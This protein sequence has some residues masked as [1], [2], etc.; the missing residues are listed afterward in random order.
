MVK[1]SS[2]PPGAKGFNAFEKSDQISPSNDQIL[3]MLRGKW[4]SLPDSRDEGPLCSAILYN[5]Y[6]IL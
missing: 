3:G 4:R 2:N 6:S 5:L 1:F